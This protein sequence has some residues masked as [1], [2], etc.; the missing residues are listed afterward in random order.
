M[1]VHTPVHAR[2][3]QQDQTLKTAWAIHPSPHRCGITGCAII[4]LCTYTVC[5]ILLGA[6]SMKVWR[7][8]VIYLGILKHAEGRSLHGKL[9][10]Q[11]RWCSRRRRLF[12]D[13]SDCTICL[14]TEA[15][16]IENMGG[17]ERIASWALCIVYRALHGIGSMPSLIPEDHH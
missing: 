3:A 17:V 16:T 2:T 4:S 12:G 9:R 8:T 13:V 10:Q 14:C 7:S 6:S 5:R 1:H 11:F 15:G